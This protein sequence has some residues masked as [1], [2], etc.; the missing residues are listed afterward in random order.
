ML[1][2]ALVFCL[3]LSFEA[4]AA[5]EGLDY[6]KFKQQ[7]DTGLPKNQVQVLQFFSYNCRHCYRLEKHLNYWLAG[8]PGEVKLVRVPVQFTPED[9]TLATVYY[10]NRVHKLDSFAHSY[11]YQG[12]L[13]AAANNKK[14]DPFNFMQLI[15]GV[16]L[17]ELRRTATG[18]IV[19][20]ELLGAM[21]LTKQYHIEAVPSFVV[22][23][24]YYTDPSLTGSYRRLL[25]VL[26]ELVKKR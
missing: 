16:E 12:V 15:S 7:F 6:L 19:R 22:N 10:V 5:I 23:G 26:N 8:L 9:K 17:N 21:Q 4:T 1:K 20:S 24:K 18:F 14:L 25:L 2:R 13:K 11:L 3:V